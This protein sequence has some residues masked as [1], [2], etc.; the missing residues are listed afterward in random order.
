MTVS[1]TIIFIFFAILSMVITPIIL[2]GLDAINDQRA[3]F[4]ATLWFLYGLILPRSWNNLGILIPM[5]GS[6]VFQIVMNKYVFFV[7]TAVNSWLRYPF[8]YGLFD[9]N[10]LYTNAL[11]GLTV[12][13]ARITV[14]FIFFILF[15]ARLD[16]TTMPGPRGNFSNFDPAYKAYVGML[17]LDHRYNNP[18]FLTFGDIMLDVLGATRVKTVLRRVNRTHLRDGYDRAIAKA[19][20]ELDSMR[21]KQ[22]PEKVEQ[23][24]RTEEG[25]IA[26]EM[27]MSLEARIRRLF[28]QKKLALWARR[29]LYFAA[30]RHRRRCV[31][32]RNRWQLWW[33]CMQQ[34]SWQRWRQDRHLRAKLDE[35]LTEHGDIHGGVSRSTSHPVHMEQNCNPNRADRFSNC[36]YA[37]SQAP[38]ESGDYL[39]GTAFQSRL[40]AYM[41]GSEDPNGQQSSVE[42]QDSPRQEQVLAV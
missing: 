42:C 15:I 37:R 34:P 30:D 11:L 7:G 33:R 5:L 12:C 9:Y 4:H 22:S 17:R 24:K 28:L 27:Q 16:K 29:I 20:A 40:F 6:L 2:S 38:D 1:T 21:D 23:M 8:W 14:L 36:D 25:Q 41:S 26:L 35:K 32:V 31:I 10:L 13:I 3:L 18:V 19:Q 39:A